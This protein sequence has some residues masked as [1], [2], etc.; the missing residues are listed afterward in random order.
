MIVPIAWTT[1]HAG[2]EGAT[3]DFDRLDFDRLD[4]SAQRG[5]QVIPSASTQDED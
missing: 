4:S 5:D 1:P 3:L 2:P